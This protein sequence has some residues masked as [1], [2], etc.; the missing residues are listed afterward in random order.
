[1]VEKGR[2]PDIVDAERVVRLTDEAFKKLNVRTGPSLFVEE[3][4]ELVEAIRQAASWPRDIWEGPF[5]LSRKQL[6]S[7]K[8]G[9]GRIGREELT[10]GVDHFRSNLLRVRHALEIKLADDRLSSEA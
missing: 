10:K 6:K 1:M 7:I 5:G 9:S 2:G 3:L 8:Y 4:P